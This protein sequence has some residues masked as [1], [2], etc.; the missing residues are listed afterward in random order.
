MPREKEKRPSGARSTEAH[1]PAKTKVDPSLN[2]ESR[3]VPLDETEGGGY[4]A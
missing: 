2:R 4:G 3:L 1:K